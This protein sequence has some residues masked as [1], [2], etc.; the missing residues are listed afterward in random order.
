MALRYSQE[1]LEKLAYVYGKNSD[2]YR[3]ARNGGAYLDC[4]IADKLGVEEKMFS[5]ENILKMIEQV[6]VEKTVE[7]VKIMHERRE[8]EKGLQ[9]QAKSEVRH[10]WDKVKVDYKEKQ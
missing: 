4:M 2:F 6:G 5:G 3:Y 9:E 8:V 1:L 7:K 10:H